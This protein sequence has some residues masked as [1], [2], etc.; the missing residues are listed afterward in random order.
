[1]PTRAITPVP[2]VPSPAPVTITFA[3]P[4]ANPVPRPV[5]VAGLTLSEAQPLLSKLLQQLESG[6]GDRVI[7][8]LEREARSKP[9]AQALSRQYDDLVAGLRPVR[10]SQVEFKAEPADGRL[11]VTGHVQLL[12]GGLAVGSPGKKMVLRAEFASR[13]GTVVMTGLSG[14]PAN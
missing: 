11:L 13:E 4:V 10:L 14:V 1:M 12:G 5:P 8:L 9:E 7:G 3:A 2:V 6:F